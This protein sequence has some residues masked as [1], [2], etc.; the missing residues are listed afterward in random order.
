MN[1]QPF[2]PPKTHVADG[3]TDT[4]RE[5]RCSVTIQ[6]PIDLARRSSY[7]SV[8]VF[9]Y[10]LPLCFLVAVE[11]LV[12]I[13]EVVWGIDA[14]GWIR[15]LPGLRAAGLRDTALGLSARFLR[16]RA[17]AAVGFCRSMMVRAAPKHMGLNSIC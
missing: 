15:V 16:S 1:T 13:V 17:M 7:R 5:M 9:A 6:S 12:D 3:K 2:E 8:P 10:D 14:D 4:M 11:V